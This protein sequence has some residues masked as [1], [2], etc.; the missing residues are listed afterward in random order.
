M[1]AR[2][3]PRR[4]SRSSASCARPS[5][6]I[7]RMAAWCGSGRSKTASMPG[8]AT[9]SRRRAALAPRRR[10][11]SLSSARFVGNDRAMLTD[12]RGLA[13]TAARA[14][15]AMRL[16]ATIAAY[17]AF[18]KDTGDRLKETLA[19]DPQLV[20]G[21]ILRGYFML[22]LVKRE[23]VA[24]ARQAAEAADAAIKAVGATPRETLHRRA[25]DAWIARD[26]T[27]AIE[28]FE[29]ILVDHP[30][31]ILALKLAQFL[32][33]YAG[34]GRRMRNTV[35]RAIASWH[36]ALPCYGFALGCHAFGLEECG[37][38]EAAERA[39]RRAVELI[40]ED[41]WGALAVAHVFEMRER[42]A[43]G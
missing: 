43:E 1:D 34:D 42:T 14:E 25:L 30:R 17:C 2:R 41:I 26:Q 24:R 27:R 29:A 6:R 20:M 3:P 19:S 31:D 23:L 38:Y 13:V 32:L 5:I 4:P 12:P 33:F 37:D 9:S 15:S 21:H 35:A 22:L 11:S 10:R 40:P 16:V 7:A 28:I 39:G 36:E 18:R 8:Q